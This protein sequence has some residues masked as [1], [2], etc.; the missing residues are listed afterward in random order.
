MTPRKRLD[1]ALF[2][3]AL[4]V[5]VL[6]MIALTACG[7]SGEGAVV[8]AQDMPEIRPNLPQV[9]QVPPPRFKLQ[10]D[11]G[12]W[13]VYGL[14]KRIR[15]NINEEVR[16]KGFVVK[17]YTPDPCPEDRTCPP[18]TMPHLW[19]GDAMDVTSERQ[20]LRLV[21][22]AN[23]QIEMDQ[24][25]EEAE[26]GQ[27]RSPEELAALPPIV[28]DWQQGKQYVVKGRFSRFAGTGFGEEI[29]L[30]EYIEHECL[31][32]PPPEDE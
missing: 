9:P 24:A 14:R 3:A 12:T 29:G 26:K 28:Y 7:D 20:L 11:N 22:Y 1:F 30:L 27:Q 18:A 6:G 4:C 2:I 15:Q 32:C 21:G 16:V 19:L 13:S 10:Y 5:A 23:S 31:D 25:R 8:V 17:I